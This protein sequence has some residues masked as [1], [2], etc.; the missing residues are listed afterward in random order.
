[1][2]NHIYLVWQ[3]SFQQKL[4][5]IHEIPHVRGCASLR[6]TIAVLQ[7]GF[8]KLVWI[9]LEYCPLEWEL[10]VGNGLKLFSA[11]WDLNFAPLVGTTDGGP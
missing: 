6:G 9:N 5:S 2:R 10:K 1:M 4:N 7:H 3:E 11:D 8:M